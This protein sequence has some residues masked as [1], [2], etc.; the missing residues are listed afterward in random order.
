[1]FESIIDMFLTAV[2]ITL[3]I[4]TSTI[5]ELVLYGSWLIIWLAVLEIVHSELDISKVQ[6]CI[7]FWFRFLAIA[8]RIL[9]YSL[10]IVCIGV[11]MNCVYY[12][13]HNL[14]NLQRCLTK[15]ILQFIS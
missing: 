12:Y 14:C 5:I 11:F 2:T 13:F 4:I 6:I 3:V 1:M 7:C 9:L 15:M 8:A 10:P